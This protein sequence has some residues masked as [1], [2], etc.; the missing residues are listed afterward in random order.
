M[1]RPYEV[2]CMLIAFC[3]QLLQ[4]LTGHYRLHYPFHVGKAQLH[5][6]TGKPE[7]NSQSNFRIALR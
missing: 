7:I 1:A 4:I 2:V 5:L 6:L 3:V